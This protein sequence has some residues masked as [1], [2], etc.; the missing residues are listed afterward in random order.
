LGTLGLATVGIL[1]KAIFNF[2]DN[3]L[4]FIIAFIPTILFNP[5]VVKCSFR[6]INSNACLNN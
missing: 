6:F 5:S 1:G 3:P 4:P 2:S